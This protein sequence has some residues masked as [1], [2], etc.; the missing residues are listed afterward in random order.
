MKKLLLYSTLILVVISCDIKKDSKEISELLTKASNETISVEERKAINQKAL[1]LVLNLENKN[2]SL[3]LNNIHKIAKTY[4]HIGTYYKKQ[5]P[6]SAYLYYTQAQK[7]YTLVQDKEDMGRVI[8]DKA[9]IQYNDG[10][11][12][13]SEMLCLEALDYFDNS[14]SK[15]KNQRYIYDTYNLLGMVADDQENYNKAIDYYNKSLEN[16]KKDIPILN[17]DLLEIVSLNNLG[18]AY[19]NIGENKKALSYF[20][21]ALELKDLHERLPHI[22]AMLLDNTAYSRVKLK[23]YTGVEELFNQALRI[24]ETLNIASGIVMSKLHMSEYYQDQKDTKQA[25]QLAN[26]AYKVAKTKGTDPRN[27]MLSL[28]QLQTVDVSSKE[29]Y[30]IEYNHIAESLQQAEPKI[31]E[32]ITQELAQA[33]AREAEKIKNQ[34]K[35][36]MVLIEFGVIACFLGVGYILNR[37]NKIKEEKL[38]RRAIT[39]QVEL[40]AYIEEKKKYIEEKKKA[41]EEKERELQEKEAQMKIYDLMVEQKTKAKKRLNQQRFSTVQKFHTELKHNLIS[42]RL[43]LETLKGDKKPLYHHH[44]NHLKALEKEVN[45]FYDFCDDL[46]QETEENYNKHYKNLLYKLFDQQRKHT[47]VNDYIDEHIQWDE[48]GNKDKMYLYYIIKSCFEIINKNNQITYLDIEMY[49]HDEQKK[50]VKV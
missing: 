47:G 29:M 10:N 16:I 2:D 40:Q 48:I 46:F 13:R 33:E 50:G 21:Q 18:V 39:L 12:A 7:Y 31:H 23:E 36:I 27:V 25:F 28:K 44:L 8:L 30:T 34:E 38:E 14:K 41:L 3:F 9:D 32:V 26:E 1:K 17:K 6:D 49:D 19:R 35:L 5:I 22:Y 15:D 45:Y 4:E 37:R 42:Q 24:R 20:A 11:L 43:F